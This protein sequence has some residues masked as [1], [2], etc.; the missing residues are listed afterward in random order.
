MPKHISISTK[1]GD[2]GTSFLADGTQHP[3]TSLVFATLGSLDELNSYIGLCV[4]LVRE[5][6]R[7]PA[8]DPAVAKLIVQLEKIQ[9][10]IYSMSAILARSPKASFSSTELRKLEQYSDALQASMAEG[11]TTRFLY[12]GGTVIGAHCDVARSMCRNSERVYWQY[13]E[14]LGKNDKQHLLVG[15]Y[16]NRVSDFLF[17]ARCFVNQRAGLV[18]KQFAQ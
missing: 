18:E 13:L 6:E 2:D 7:A 9:H 11:W 8:A 15:K 17:I 14:S 12:P 16:L 3:K 5:G 1:K 10:N 4:A